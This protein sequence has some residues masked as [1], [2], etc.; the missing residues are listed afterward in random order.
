MNLFF[1]GT[2]LSGHRAIR[3]QMTRHEDMS[4]RLYFPMYHIDVEARLGTF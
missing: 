3:T 4:S 2:G 1:A